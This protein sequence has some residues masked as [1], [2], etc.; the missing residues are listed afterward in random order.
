MC[1]RRRRGS[2]LSRKALE[3]K[4]RRRQST[5]VNYSW[6]FPEKSK[7]RERLKGG[8]A[9]SKES[10]RVQNSDR[11]CRSGERPGAREGRL[12]GLERL[13]CFEKRRARAWPPTN[14]SSL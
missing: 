4:G 7:V 1:N 12:G 6:L 14:F 3:K 13:L 8:D 5:K 2:T 10:G 9:L 11:S